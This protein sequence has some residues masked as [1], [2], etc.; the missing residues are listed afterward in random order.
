MKRGTKRLALPSLNTKHLF[1][2]TDSTGILQHA[3]FSVPNYKEG[4]TTDDN[5]RA[6]I[7]ALRLYEKTGDKLYLTL[8]IDTWHFYTMLTLRMAF[9]E[10]L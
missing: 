8:F 2:M 5:A 7:V 3:K 9:S 6:L 4:Y 1:R 10:T